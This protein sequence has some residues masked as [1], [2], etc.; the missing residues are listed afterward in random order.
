[1]FDYPCAF[2]AHRFL[3]PCIDDFIEL[4]RIFFIQV[5]QVVGYAFLNVL[6]LVV[7]QIR[8]NLDI[9]V[10]MLQSGIDFFAHGSR[11]LRHSLESL[12]TLSFSS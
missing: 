2:F 12:R 11:I 6:V 5:V 10:E 3:F 7:L 9:T 8:E 1:M 4:I